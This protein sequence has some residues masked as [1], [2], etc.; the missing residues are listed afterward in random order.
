[1]SFMTGSYNML[2]NLKKFIHDESG[3]AS[4]EYVML[5]FMIVSA[6]IFLK[7]ILTSFMDKIVR[8]QLGQ[9]ILN[10]FFQPDSMHRFPIRIPK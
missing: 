10:N 7:T 6:I 2:T 9:G 4:T 5:I 1:M 8:G 3:Q